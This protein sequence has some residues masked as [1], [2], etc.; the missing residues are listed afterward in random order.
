M[1]VVNIHASCV[2]LAKA[3]ALFGAPSDGGVLLLGESGAG[4]SSVVLKLLALGAM[5][6]ADDRVDLFVRDES[7]YATAPAP[8]AGLIEARGLG[9]VK[10]PHAAE[11]R[12]ALAVA[13]GPAPP[14][15]PDRED[16]EPP[17]PLNVRAKPP[18][19]RL[20]AEDMAVAEKIV[21]A[22]AAFSNALFRQ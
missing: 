12:V 5:L 9:I 17:T 3:G 18:L 21:L 7:L 1:T 16:Y 2:V 8:L 6:V 10:L 20:S 22:A 11:S 13:L 19:F 15:Y 14:R 4:K